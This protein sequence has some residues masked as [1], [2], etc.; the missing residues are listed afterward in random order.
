MIKINL[1]GV[2]KDKIKIPIVMGMDFRAV[3]WTGIIVSI[4]I[5]FGAQEGINIY[6]GQEIDKIK[7]NTS[8]NAI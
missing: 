3:S 8:K 1:L 7:E 4:I 2:K 5:Y 6:Y